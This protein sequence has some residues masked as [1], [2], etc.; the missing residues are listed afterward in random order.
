MILTGKVCDRLSPLR[1]G[2]LFHH[3]PT[4]YARVN[5]VSPARQNSSGTL[6]V[7]RFFKPLRKQLYVRSELI[8]YIH[9]L[10]VCHCESGVIL[11][12]NLQH[13]GS[14][15]ALHPRSVYRF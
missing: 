11:G 6:S 7:G 4:R 13:R 9:Y 14:E 15:N 3:A 12:G 5:G 8:S 1:P 10:P 2:T